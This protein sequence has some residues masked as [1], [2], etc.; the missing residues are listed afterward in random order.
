MASAAL[1]S[2]T[3]LK[4]R[5]RNFDTVG[6]TRLFANAIKNGDW[7]EAS[8]LLSASAR[9]NFG[10]TIARGAADGENETRCL[11]RWDEMARLLWFEEANVFELDACRTILIYRTRL[12]E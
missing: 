7:A 3:K 6:H 9:L 5:K 4:P 1:F 8:M 11:S 2:T 12:T 10:K